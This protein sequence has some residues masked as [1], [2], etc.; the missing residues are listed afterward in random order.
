MKKKYI[1]H[2]PHFIY[3]NFIKNFI[4]IFSLCS[5]PKSKAIS[6]INL[7]ISG[8]GNQ[9]IINQ[10]FNPSPSEVLVNDVSIALCNICN[11]PNSSPNKITLKFNSDINSCENMFMDLNNIIE[12]DLS[13]FDASKSISM[14][15]M[16][17]G[18]TSL[19]K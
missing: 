10:A 16:F 5:L 3:L 15:N 11:L 8:T 9:K 17:N 19:K 4:I 2:S 6:E 1:F 12:I 13:N 14:S 7:F 18:C